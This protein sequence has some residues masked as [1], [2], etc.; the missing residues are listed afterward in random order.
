MDTQTTMELP[1]IQSSMERYLRCDVDKRQSDVGN[2][3]VPKITVIVNGSWSKRSHKFTYNALGG[4]GA[5]IGFHTKQ[6][7][8]LAIKNKYCYIK[9]PKHKCF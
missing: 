5:I 1:A 8:F 4:I 2:D 9:A 7:L 3:S 6:V